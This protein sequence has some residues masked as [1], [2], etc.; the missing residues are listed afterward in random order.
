M[1]A[2]SPKREVPV[3]QVQGDLVLDR[4][5]FVAPQLPAF[6]DDGGDANKPFLVKPDSLLVNLKAQRFITRAEGGKVNIAMRPPYPYHGRSSAIRATASRI[7]RM[8]DSVAPRAPSP[9]RPS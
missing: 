3:R 8:L 6:N 4:S 5:F 7:W 1:L 9:G 2:P